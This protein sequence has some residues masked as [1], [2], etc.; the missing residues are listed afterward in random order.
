MNVGD[1]VKFEDPFSETL[2]GEIVSVN[3]PKCK[4]KGLGHYIVD[5]DGETRQIKLG[6]ERLSL[7]K[8][9][10]SNG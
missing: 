5:F 8:N 6:D 7:Y 9:D 1:K 10:S 2:I 3:K 4:C